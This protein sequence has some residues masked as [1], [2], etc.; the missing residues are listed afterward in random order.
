MSDFFLEPA[1]HIQTLCF[2]L[3]LF[4][5]R[6]E[7]VFQMSSILLKNTTGSRRDSYIQYDFGQDLFGYHFLDIGRRQKHRGK[8]LKRMNFRTPREFL[9]TLDLELYRK[10]S[11]NYIPAGTIS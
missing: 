8:I 11:L 3:V 1:C 4:S 9:L 2:F 7:N 6:A 5:V 10:E